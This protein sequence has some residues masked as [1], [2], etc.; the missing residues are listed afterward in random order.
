M[1]VFCNIYIYFYS[2][3]GNGARN[4]FIVVAARVYTCIYIYVRVYVYI[5]SHVHAC[6][7]AKR[8]KAQRLCT[9]TCIYPLYVLIKRGWM[10]LVVVLYHQTQL[11]RYSELNCFRAVYSALVCPEVITVTLFHAHFHPQS[12]IGRAYPLFFLQYI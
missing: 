2:N 5:K 9:H 10:S 12:R 7:R 4:A 6:H 1:W 11:K 3:Y 8:E